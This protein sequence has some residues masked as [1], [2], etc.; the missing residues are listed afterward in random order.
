MIRTCVTIVMS[1]TAINR[2]N[3]KKKYISRNIKNQSMTIT[4]GVFWSTMY[5]IAIEK[6]IDKVVPPT[7]PKNPNIDCPEVIVIPI[8]M[9]IIA[10]TLSLSAK[11]Q[12]DVMI[13]A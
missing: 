7:R 10:Q 12:P 11:F 13:F 8:A 3:F 4:P 1:Q 2:G 5:Q 6:T 9:I